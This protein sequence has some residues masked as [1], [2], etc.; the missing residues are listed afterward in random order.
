MRVGEESDEKQQKVSQGHLKKIALFGIV[1][2]N[3]KW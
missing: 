1:A 3:K 2:C